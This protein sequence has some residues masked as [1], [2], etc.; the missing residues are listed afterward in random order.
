MH[1]AS[2]SRWQAQ[3]RA[4]AKATSRPA[5]HICA[6]LHFASS[7]APIAPTKGAMERAAMVP[8]S[9][10]NARSTSDSTPRLSA[11]LSSL[12]SSSWTS[13]TSATEHS[14]ASK[15]SQAKQA[16]CSLDGHDQQT[17]HGFHVSQHHGLHT[18]SDS[19]ANCACIDHIW[20]SYSTFAL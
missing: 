19:A 14:Q 1:H 20:W 17:L 2:S 4:K 13:H 9:V 3:K 6:V 18:D 5:G 11:V 10:S 7:D 16:E 12:S 8:G 15:P